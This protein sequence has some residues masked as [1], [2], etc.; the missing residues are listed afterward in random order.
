MMKYKK[1]AFLGGL[2]LIT[3]AGIQI[4]QHTKNLIGTDKKVF[5]HDYHDSVA[6]WAKVLSSDKY[7]FK[8]ADVVDEFGGALAQCRLDKSLWLNIPLSRYFS[9]EISELIFQVIGV[10]LNCFGVIFLITVVAKK[11]DLGLWILASLFGLCAAAVTF[12]PQDS[13]YMGSIFLVF[14]FIIHF[15]QKNKNPRDFF[16]VS[17]CFNLV[18]CG[19]TLGGS[20]TLLSSIIVLLLHDS[21]QE[22]SKAKTTKRVFAVFAGFVISFI[23]MNFDQ[24]STLFKSYGNYISHRTEFIMEREPILAQIMNL[25]SLDSDPA[26]SYSFW[27]DFKGFWACILVSFIPSS[28]LGSRG[29][30]WAKKCRNAILI[31]LGVTIVLSVL[32]WSKEMEAAGILPKSLDLIQFWR[33][34][35]AAT[36]AL[37]SA[38][39]ISSLIIWNGKLFSKIFVM[40]AVLWQ[41]VDLKAGQ[42]APERLRCF[43]SLSKYYSDTSFQKI[44]S[45]ITDCD[46]N[47]RVGCL[48]FHPALATYHGFYTVDFYLADYDLRYKHKFRKI[49]A[50]ELEKKNK[51]DFGNYFDHWGSRA[52]LFCNEYGN[53]Y[54]LP[55]EKNKDIN[56]GTP[57]EGMVADWGFDAQAFKELGG[58]YIISVIP[59]AHPESIHLKLISQV[60]EKESYW[61]FWIYEAL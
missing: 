50:K 44:S 17:L 3:I 45:L 55:R 57:Y 8:H 10:I 16:L 59:L 58:K 19:L 1:F 21:S 41:L 15:I 34:R 18:V 26:I 24:I 30:F 11:R 40:G 54:I 60:S 61:N 14:G 33:I 22:I 43:L 5:I 31:S 23:F 25:W 4:N 35:Y 46:A 9:K 29:Y 42:A 32:V 47:K 12:R 51:F 13:P 27:R 2:I 39:L 48:G 36:P 7:F 49:I 53:R 52:Y 28:F 6:T 37:I 56:L 20:G 38:S